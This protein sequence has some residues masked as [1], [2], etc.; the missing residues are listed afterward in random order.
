MVIYADKLVEAN[1]PPRVVV[2]DYEFIG[3]V[4][5]FEQMIPF[6]EKFNRILDE[7]PP[8]KE[9][10]KIAREFLTVIFPPPELPPK[11]V[12]PKAL[13]FWEGVKHWLFGKDPQRWEEYVEKLDAWENEVDKLKENSAVEQIMKS[14]AL[15][16]ICGQLFT[17][18][19]RA[20]GLIQE[21]A[22]ETASSGSAQ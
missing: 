4:L 2:G 16:K 14:P 12:K 11:P 7:A 9:Q 8:L 22:Q 19:M 20:M 21:V 10:L 6:E 15:F 17:C 5:S 1:E 3:K 18:Q 13:S